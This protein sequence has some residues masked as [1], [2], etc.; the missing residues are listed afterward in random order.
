VKQERQRL[1]HAVADAKVPTGRVMRPDARKDQL[2]AF[3]KDW[4]SLVHGNVIDARQL[5]GIALDDRVGL[6]QGPTAV[7]L[8]IP[9]AFDR[10]IIAAVS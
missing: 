10:V 9:S 4:P 1:R 6:K 3:L 2:P 7:S 8:R 5:I